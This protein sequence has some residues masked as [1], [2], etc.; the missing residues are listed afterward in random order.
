[1]FGAKLREEEEESVY[2]KKVANGK[3]LSS[4]IKP[5]P[6]EAYRSLA[7]QEKEEEEFDLE[8]DLEEEEEERV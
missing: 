5:L 2:S 8:K 4:L 3:P 6:H 1:L 7:L